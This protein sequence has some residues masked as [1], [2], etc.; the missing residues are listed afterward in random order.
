MSQNGDLHLFMDR[1]DRNMLPSDPY[2]EHTAYYTI[3]TTVSSSPNTIELLNRM[4]LMTLIVEE[5]LMKE[6]GEM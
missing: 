5:R 4:A 2:S 6:Y 1:L 3:K